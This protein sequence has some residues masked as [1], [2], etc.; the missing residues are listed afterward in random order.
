MPEAESIQNIINILS[1]E[2]HIEGGYFRRTYAAEP[3]NGKCFASSIYYLLTAQ[4]PVG[5]L[6]RNR[7]DIIHYFHSGQSFRYT[8]IDTQGNLST[9]TLGNNIDQGETPQ[10]LVKGGYWKASELLIDQTDPEQYG[11]ISEAV[12]PG[13]NYQD[14]Q[15]ATGH[16][17]LTLW[18]QHQNTLQHLIKKA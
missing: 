9:V 12:V 17:L 1:L 10:L 15:I 11:L 6:H 7:S 14:M 5:H 4:S 3:E 16:D 8:L 2:P 13:F 18:P